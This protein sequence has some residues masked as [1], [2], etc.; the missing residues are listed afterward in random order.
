MPPEDEGGP[1]A[2]QGM[3]EAPQ[4]LSQGVALGEAR[5]PEYEA[6][7]DERVGPGQLAPAGGGEGPTQRKG[8][9]PSPI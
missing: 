6:P 3:K 5:A 8:G 1:Q 4:N 2:M 7:W 9:S